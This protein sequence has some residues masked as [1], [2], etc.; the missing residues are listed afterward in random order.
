MPESCLWALDQFGRAYR[1]SNLHAQWQP[2][3]SGRSKIRH[4]RKLAAATWVVW[5]VGC[6]HQAYL[7]VPATDLKIRVQEVVFEN[8]RWSPLVGFSG[9]CGRSFDCFLSSTCEAYM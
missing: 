8:E 7:F 9:K 3:S 5:S 6:D 1:L 2:V 4:F